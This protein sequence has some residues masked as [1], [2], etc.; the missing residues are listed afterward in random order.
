METEITKKLLE[1]AIV[2]SM[3][4]PMYLSIVVSSVRPV[5]TSSV[6]DL[7]KTICSERQTAS[8]DC[9]L[10]LFYSF[11]WHSIGKSHSVCTEGQRAPITLPF[12]QI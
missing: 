11:N 10:I 12:H 5:K 2:Q 4:S 9:Q 8:A 3:I 7:S 6:H 1:P